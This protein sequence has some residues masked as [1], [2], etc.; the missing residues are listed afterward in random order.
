MIPFATF[1][2]FG[3]LLYVV[4][5]TIVLGLVGK[6]SW[7]WVLV[8]TL[9]MLAIQYGGVLANVPQATVNDLWFLVGYALLEYFVAAAFL[10]V[11]TRTKARGVY[12]GALFLALAPLVLAKALPLVS[13]AWLFGFL[14]ISYV[15]FRSLDVIFGIQDN[16]ITS[17]PFGSYFAFV[18]FFATIS[19]GP[20]DRYRRFVKD[21]YHSR[22]RAE[23]LQDL[24]GAAHHI[25]I[26]FLYK[27]ILGALVKQYWLDPV[28]NGTDLW[29]NILYMYAY[30]FYL[31]FDFAGYSAFAI[32]A[33]YIFGIHTPENFNRPF[34][35]SSIA[36]FWNRWHITLS[37]WFRDHIYMRL[38]MASAKNHWIKNKY[39]ASYLALFVSFGLMGLW[40]GTTLN[41]LVYGV[42]HGALLSG[43]QFFDRWNKTHHLWGDSLPWR[44]AGIVTT[45]HLVCLGF[46]IF[47]GHLFPGEQTVAAAAPAYDGVLE[48]VT[49]DTVRGWA[50]QSAQPDASV[51]LNVYD[52]EFIAMNSLPADQARPDLPL[53]KNKAHGFQL[54]LPALFK[55]G[56]EH[57]LSVRVAGARLELRGSPQTIR[58]QP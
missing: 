56:K 21:W 42:Y 46:L 1:T 25:F 49:C 19:S 11:H 55:D 4:L 48:S 47:S 54:A 44:I 36:D 45:F 12:Y 26:G 33:S 29:S 15:T 28:T 5:P 20:I 39:Y 22:T 53:G 43:H 17:L 6:I 7:R 24:D 34:L 51:L 16:L 10:Y 35:A 3:V 58:C 9:V 32:G 52:S 57:S 30:S 8:A 23:F 41:Y 38:L 50:W 18:F 40:H 31:F 37:T 14:G 13:P 2:Y 27:F